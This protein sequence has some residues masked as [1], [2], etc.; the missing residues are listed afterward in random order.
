[1][2]HHEHVGECLVRVFAV[3]TAYAMTCA[4]GVLAALARFIPLAL[5]FFVLFKLF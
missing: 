1:M 5:L 4:I 2:Y 3:W